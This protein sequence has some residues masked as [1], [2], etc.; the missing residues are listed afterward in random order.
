[1][2][3]DLQHALEGAAGL[4]AVWMVYDYPDAHGLSRLREAKPGC[5]IFLDL[6]DPSQAMRVAAEIDTNYP[7]AEQIAIDAGNGREELLGLM[8]LGVREV[9][10]HPFGPAEVE[11]ALMR[12]RRKL[13]GGPA[14]SGNGAGE[15]YAF[16]PAKPGAGA[17]TLAASTA[18][19]VARL[20]QKRTLLADFDVKLGIT[21]FLLKLDG[22]NS[23]LDA[24]DQSDWMNEELW[25]RLVSERGFLDVL[26]SS[27]ASYA[28][29]RPASDFLNLLRFAQTQYP[30][31]LVDLPGS[32]DEHEVETL[33]MAKQ[34]FLVCTPDVSGLHMARRKYE[35]AARLGLTDRLALVLNR[36]GARRA[37]S[38]ADIERVVQLPVRHALPNDEKAVAEAVR[39][40]EPLRP[41]CA[42][43]E[44]V[45]ALARRILQGAAGAE[46]PERRRKFV[47]YFSISS[48][49]AANS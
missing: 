1:M 28:R 20:S 7:W 21:S 24:L 11:A 18:A 2:A 9:I 14:A 25:A 17:S 39:K 8:R 34:I 30:A 41:G 35:L 32:M 48:A 33:A 5:V 6:A 42:L 12:A 4:E 49:R 45:E 10:T 26:G 22:Q 19:A 46:S 29:A 3:N 16:T 27:P 43:G 36:S 37:L 15:V 44:Q 23:V 13:K 47:D 40:G 31:V 38:I